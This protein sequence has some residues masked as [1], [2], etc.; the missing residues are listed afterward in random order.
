MH[1]FARRLNIN[2]SSP[3][4]P[5]E[6]EEEEKE[7]EKKEEMGKSSLGKGRN[8]EPETLFLGVRRR[9]FCQ[10]LSKYAQRLHLSL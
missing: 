7:E 2:L 3:P 8:S 5:T 4:E 9:N 1:Q 6:P 10:K